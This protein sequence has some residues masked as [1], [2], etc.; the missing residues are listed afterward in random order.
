VRDVY[1]ECRVIL[2][3]GHAMVDPA[4][5]AVKLGA[6][7]YLCKPLPF[8][9]LGALLTDAQEDLARRRTLLEADTETAKRIELCGMIGRGQL[10]ENLL[11]L[12]KRLAPHVRT[13][14]VT[15]ETGTGKELIARALHQLGPQSRKRFVAVNCAAVVEGLFESELFGHVRG[16]FTGASDTKAGLFEAAD[17]GTLFL[18]EVGELPMTVQAK[19]L[20]ILETGELHRVGSLEARK[21]DVRIVA[22]TN[23]NLD[24]AVA[25]GRFRRDLLYRLNVVQIGAP[26]LRDRRDD[27]PYLTAAFIAGCRERFQ[28]AVSGVTP[29]AEAVLRE[30]E[31][32]GNVRELRNVLERACLL[33]DG[34]LLTDRDVARA[35]PAGSSRSAGA[36]APAHAGRTARKALKQVQFDEIER[37]LRET[38]GNKSAVARRLGVSRRALY[39]RLDKHAGAGISS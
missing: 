32:P 21:V 3:T 13:A 29:A 33:A 15:G 35:L 26:P 14:L 24:E 31:W 30:Y 4:I 10:M 17:G 9:R 8:D 28:T 20:R 34:Q 39:R 27:V 18:D 1:E 2:M 37:A 12:L 16:A 22:A 38:A 36:S 25:A 6:H 23:R 5:E 7:D 11:A 19:L